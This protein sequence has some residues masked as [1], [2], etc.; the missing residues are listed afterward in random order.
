MWLLTFHSKIP[1][2]FFAARERN[3]E[4]QDSEKNPSWSGIECHR[5]EREMKV[6]YKI[7]ISN[8]NQ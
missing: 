3:K 7:D 1:C 2:R 5:V 8:R 6:P 4:E